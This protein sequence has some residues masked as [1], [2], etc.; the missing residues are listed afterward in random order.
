MASLRLHK[1]NLPSRLFI[2]NQ[3]LN[4]AL[5]LKETQKETD[6]TKLFPD[7][8]SGVLTGDAFTA[9][10]EA[11][12]HAWEAQLAAKE[13]RKLTWEGKKTT[14]S[15]MENIIGSAPGEG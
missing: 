15:G 7:E 12:A 13:Q 6:Y 14:K 2:I 10:M 5:H 11:A 9:K 1:N 3:C 8:K 4:Q